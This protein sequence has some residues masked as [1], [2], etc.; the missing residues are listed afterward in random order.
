MSS[1]I[2]EFAY[3]GAGV[4]GRALGVVEVQRAVE[5][6][7]YTFVEVV[8]RVAHDVAGH[9]SGYVDEG[10]GDR[11]CFCR[12]PD[13]DGLAFKVGAFGDAG[14]VPLRRR[15]RAPLLFRV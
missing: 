13:V 10:L 9:L 4:G 15:F 14:G 3:I 12:V 11:G 8:D 7:L 5:F 6:V 1:D 2:Y